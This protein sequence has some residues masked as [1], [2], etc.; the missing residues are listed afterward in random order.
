MDA[1]RCKGCGPEQMH[2]ARAHSLS[3]DDHPAEPPASRDTSYGE[4]KGRCTM[5]GML[6]QG[7]P[8]HTMQAMAWLCTLSP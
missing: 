5:Q 3:S 7:C 8:A 6:K 1:Q 2:A 4:L